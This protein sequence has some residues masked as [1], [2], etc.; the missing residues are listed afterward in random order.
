MNQHI[1]NIAFPDNPPAELW[2]GICEFFPESEQLNAAHI[3]YLESKWDAFALADTVT[4]RNP[5]GS[6]VSNRGGILITAERSVGYFQINSCNFPEWEWERFY[7]ARHNCGTAHLVYQRAAGSWSPWYFSAVALGLIP[8]ATSEDV[9]KA[10]SRLNDRG[11]LA[12]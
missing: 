6:V 9:G 11:L 8:A 4:P 12:A 7:N 3:S 1:F 5:C 10:W 2:D